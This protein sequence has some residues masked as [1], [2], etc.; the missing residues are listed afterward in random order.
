MSVRIHSWQEKYCKVMRC[1]AYPP[2]NAPTGFRSGMVAVDVSSIILD[3]WKF[4][5]AVVRRGD[6]MVGLERMRSEG[7]SNLEAIA[8]KYLGW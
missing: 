2:L 6:A 7:A 1:L 3:D 8:L 5:V 4:R